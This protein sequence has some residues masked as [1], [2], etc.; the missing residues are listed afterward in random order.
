MLHKSCSNFIADPTVEI[1]KI[2][3]VGFSNYIPHPVCVTGI[4][5]TSLKMDVG[6]I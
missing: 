2:Q 6:K 4:V 5:L 3:E 1:S